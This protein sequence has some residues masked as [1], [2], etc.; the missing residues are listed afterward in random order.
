MFHHAFDHAPEE[1]EIGGKLLSMTKGTQGATEYAMEFKT[2][3][4]GS[5]WNEPVLKAAYCQ[6]LNIVI[7]F[8][9]TCCK[10]IAIPDT[11]P[12]EKM[13]TGQIKLTI[14]KGNSK[15]M[16][17]ASCPMTVTTQEDVCYTLS[18]L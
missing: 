9:I 17:S 8:K 3:A 6:E 7:L 12:T 16:P 11:S 14:L 4:S 1:K 18:T 10:K 5:G 15:E 13:P 2:L